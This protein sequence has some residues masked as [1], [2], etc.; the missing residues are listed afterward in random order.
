MRKLIVCGVENVI[1]IK[2][3][4][5]CLVDATVL[6]YTIYIP[7]SGVCEKKNNDGQTGVHKSS[8]IRSKWMTYWPM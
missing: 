3:S 7:I 5:C 1:V 2:M 8:P 4:F 6:K